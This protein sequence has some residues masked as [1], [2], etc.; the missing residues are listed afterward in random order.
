[1]RRGRKLW[2]EQFR[3]YQLWLDLKEEIFHRRGG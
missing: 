3:A 2:G 1:M